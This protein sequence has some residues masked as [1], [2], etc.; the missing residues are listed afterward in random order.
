LIS[1]LPAE[2]HIFPPA[3]AQHFRQAI[4]KHWEEI[5][6]S[7]SRLHEDEW[8]L[9]VYS[10]NYTTKECCEMLLANVPPLSPMVFVDEKKNGMVLLGVALA[11]TYYQ[12]PKDKR[13]KRKLGPDW[14]HHWQE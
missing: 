5:K 6:D 13:K 14:S 4:T 10:P 1:L 11:Q 8:G 7:S 2:I 3:S 12:M 9:Q